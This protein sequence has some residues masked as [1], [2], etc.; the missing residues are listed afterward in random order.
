[1]RLF[2]INADIRKYISTNINQNDQQAKQFAHAKLKVE[3]R[4]YTH[5]LQIQMEVFREKKSFMRL[6]LRSS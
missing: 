6:F 4:L 3:E 1:M 2:N 5:N